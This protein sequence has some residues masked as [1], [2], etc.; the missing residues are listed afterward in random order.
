MVQKKEGYTAKKERRTLQYL[1]WSIR[2]QN[3]DL[4][5]LSKGMLLRFRALKLTLPLYSLSNLFRPFLMCLPSG[6]VV[7]RLSL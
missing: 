4:S 1:K 6:A 5:P 2:N 7:I 3:S